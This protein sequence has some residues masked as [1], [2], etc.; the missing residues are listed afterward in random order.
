MG[1]K[2]PN[3]ACARLEIDKCLS[4]IHSPYNDGWTQM[5]CKHELY[6]LKYWL[7]AEYK[8]LPTFAGEETWE[9]NK[10]IEILKQ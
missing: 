4:E 7:E 8:K 1:F 10:I 2:Q 6:M 9:Q 3:L 5:S